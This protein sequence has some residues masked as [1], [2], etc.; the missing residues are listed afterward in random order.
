[1]SDWRAETSS[2]RYSLAS[3]LLEICLYL[4]VKPTYTTLFFSI[5]A[6]ILPLIRHSDEHME[7]L[8][9]RNVALRQRKRD[10]TTREI[11]GVNGNARECPQSCLRE[12]TKTIYIPKVRNTIT[13]STK[14]DAFLFRSVHLFRFTARILRAFHLPPLASIL[15]SRIG[16]YLVLRFSNSRS[17]KRKLPD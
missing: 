13:L 11:N 9:F 5:F 17:S 12:E 14:H 16:M 10:S 15:P 1:M 4:V 7:L 8:S 2:R 6:C 3:F